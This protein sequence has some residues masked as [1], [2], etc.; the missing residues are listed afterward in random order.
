MRF[1]DKVDARGK[2]LNEV[3][4]RELK[5][6]THELRKEMADRQRRTP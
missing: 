6:I 3:N 2:K 1:N 4:A 5:E